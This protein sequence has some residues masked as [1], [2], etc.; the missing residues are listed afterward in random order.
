MGDAKGLPLAQDVRLVGDRASVRLRTLSAHV[1]QTLP[2]SVGAVEGYLD[3]EEHG[4]LELKQNSQVY[5]LACSYIATN[6]EVHSFRYSPAAVGNETV[7]GAENADAPEIQLTTI[8]LGVF[9]FR[10]EGHDLYALHQAQGQPVGSNAGVELFTSLVLFA[11]RGEQHVL[12]HFCHELVEASER[13]QAGFTNVFEWNASNQFWHARVI[14]PVRPLSSVVLQAS[15]QARLLEDVEEFVG[16]DARQWYRQHGIQ[17]KRGYLFHG[18]PGTGKTSLVQ[19]LAG[20]LEYNICQVHLSHPRMT[21]DSLRAAVNQAPRKSLLV[22]EDID[23]VFGR[24]REK[25]LQDSPLT[26]S[27]L[28]NALDGVGKADGQIFVLTTNHRERLNPALIRSGRADV[29]VEFT[30]ASDEQIGGMFARFYPLS[31][32]AM[33]QEF[34]ARLRSVLGGQEV[35]PATLQHFF[36]LHRRRTPA[37]ALERVGEILEELMAREDERRQREWDQARVKSEKRAAGSSP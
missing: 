28:L 27:G 25:L 35:S 17:H 32:A 11:P 20:H 34:V 2:F 16:P 36:I 13:V 9:P 14:C 33:A 23:A 4:Y 15:M 10:W 7:L 22:F 19:A 12:G 26:F 5:A 8:G 3:V 24:D 18:P 30:H 1:T 31:G 29:H 21:D 6:G 37:R